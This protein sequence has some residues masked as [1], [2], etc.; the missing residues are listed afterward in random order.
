MPSFPIGSSAPQVSTSGSGDL[1]QLKL[2]VSQMPD[3]S[4]LPSGARGAGAERFGFPS[5]VLGRPA[6]GYFRYWAAT[7]A[8]QLSA[9]VAAIANR[10]DRTIDL[11][12]LR[13]QIKAE[14][15]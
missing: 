4:G 15:P 2:S 5:A 6:V 9:E 13:H 14:L 3:K 7:A 11:S 12:I 1:A 10:A 8:D